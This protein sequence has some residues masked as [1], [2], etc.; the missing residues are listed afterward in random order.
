MSLETA[1]DAPRLP[2]ARGG[3]GARAERLARRAGV[4]LLRQRH[5]YVVPQHPRTGGGEC[6]G[7]HER[8]GAR[9]QG[10]AAGH[11]QGEPHL[12]GAAGRDAEPARTGGV[13]EA[14]VAEQ[15]RLVLLARQ[16]G[17]RHRQGAVVAE[18]EAVGQRPAVV[19]AHLP[20]GPVRDRE[21]AGGVGAGDR[22]RPGRPQP[23]RV[24]RDGHAGPARHHEE[25]EQEHDQLAAHDG[26][27]GSGHRCAAGRR[28]GRRARARRSRR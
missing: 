6:H 16:P 26:L 5:L 13:G 10:L 9:R 20:D 17:H 12:P 19:V 7:P 1:L 24:L 21:H 28:P 3:R 2:A 27:S 25:G 15:P 22:G 8:S 4:Q 23:R 11:P 18:L 14:Q